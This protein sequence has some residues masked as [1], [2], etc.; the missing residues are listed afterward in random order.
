MTAPHTLGA[1]TYL[2]CRKV[3]G[4]SDLGLEGQFF[5]GDPLQYGES[6]FMLASV[7]EGSYAGTRA[8]G[9]V[10]YERT[11]HKTF[12]NTKSTR[13]SK[14]FDLAAM[15]P[16]NMKTSSTRPISNPFCCWPL[17]DILVYKHCQL[18]FELSV[19]TIHK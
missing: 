14:P 13:L 7:G 9:H 16:A 5:T 8:K 15:I 3:A 10:A 6:P 19:M 18:T 12:D 4:T 2:R 1:F 17:A 11:T